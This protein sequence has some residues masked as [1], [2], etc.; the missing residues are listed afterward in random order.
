MADASLNPDRALH[1][2]EFDALA[3]TL[4]DVLARDF[5]VPARG[6]CVVGIAGESGSGKSV[7]ATTLARVLGTRG[8][9]AAVLY[10]DDYFRR[11]PRVNHAA[12]LADLAAVGPHEVNLLL[13]AEQV[14]AFRAGADAV[15]GPLV[16]YAN[17]RFLTQR[18]ALAGRSVLIVEGTYALHL[19]DLDVRVFLEATHLDTAERRAARA[20]DHH[21]PIIDVILDIEHRIIARQAERAHVVVDREFRVVRRP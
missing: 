2:P 10:Q 18:H 3:V 19:D 15:E 13:L 1:Q 8:V 14:A 4:A 9:A 20:R 17:D 12:R 16:D 6:R 21:E 11:P 7:T 5:G